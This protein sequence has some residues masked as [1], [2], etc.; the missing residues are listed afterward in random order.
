MSQV[1]S[2]KKSPSA[3]AGGTLGEELKHSP[4]VKDAIDTIVSEVRRRSAQITD[5]RPANPGLKESYDALMRRAG[6]VRGRGLLYPYLGSGLGNGALV[7]LADGSVKWD[8]ICGIG[9]HFFGTRTRTSSP[10]AC[11]ARWMTR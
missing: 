7:E 8:M 11:G 3:A 1:A 9:V 5:I 6:E 4:A 2:P 10:R